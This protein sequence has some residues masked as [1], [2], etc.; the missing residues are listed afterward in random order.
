[1]SKKI[2]SQ[3]IR[4]LLERKGIL[5]VASAMGETPSELKLTFGSE[6]QAAEARKVLIGARIAAEH[7]NLAVTVFLDA[8]EE[9]QHYHGKRNAA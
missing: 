3:K 6:R 4:R 5:P 7:Y 9:A 1:M 2:E 8:H